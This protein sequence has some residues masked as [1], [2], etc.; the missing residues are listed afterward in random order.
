MTVKPFEDAGFALKPGEISKVVK[1]EFGYHIIKLEEISPERQKALEECSI[2]IEYILL[3]E[4]QQDA[5]TRWL[6]SLKDEYNVQ[7][8]E[9]LLN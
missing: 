5:F 3:P 4:K 1:T 9:E 2:E 8:K 6:S 7:I